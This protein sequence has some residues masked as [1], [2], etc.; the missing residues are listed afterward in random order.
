M[1]CWGVHGE[2]RVEVVGLMGD[3]G[4]GGWLD[5]YVVDDIFL[6]IK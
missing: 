1:G 3:G 2:E 6:R 5:L 4:I